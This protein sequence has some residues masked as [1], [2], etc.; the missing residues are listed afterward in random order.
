VCA[1]PISL[2]QD[3]PLPIQN[4]RTV[5]AR[6]SVVESMRTIQYMVQNV[7]ECETRPKRM[8]KRM[9]EL[10]DLMTRAMRGQVAELILIWHSAMIMDQKEK[11]HQRMMDSM[12][13]A[14]DIGKEK[15][16]ETGSGNTFQCGASAMQGRRHSMEDTHILGGEVPGGHGVV[17]AIFDGHGGIHAAEYAKAQFVNCLGEQPGWSRFR[18][19]SRVEAAKEA[20]EQAFFTLD[21]QMRC[22]VPESHDCGCTAVVLLLT[23]THL[24]AANAGDARCIMQ[25][26]E[27]VEGLTQDHKPGNEAEQCRIKAAGGIVYQHRVNGMLAVSRSLGDFA[28]KARPELGKVA[29]LVSPEPEITVRARSAGDQF[30]MLGCDGIWDVADNQTCARLVGQGLRTEAGQGGENVLGR[31]CENVLEHC[32]LRHS[33]DN[34]SAMI[35]QLQPPTVAPSIS[36]TPAGLSKGTMD[37]NHDGVIDRAEWTNAIASKVAQ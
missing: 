21:D 10:R 11:L 33:N 19:T 17:F 8:G 13:R 9:R 3:A 14:A 22:E 16:T 7:D 36:R 24:L 31:V 18:E 23:A 28:F 4:G 25:V 1:A 27:R 5:H 30:V 29:Q 26:G 15:H 6:K 37:T 12:K 32:Y 35:I 2:S 20:L 34:M